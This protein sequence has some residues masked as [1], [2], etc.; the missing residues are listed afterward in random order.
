MNTFSLTKGRVQLY[1]SIS[2]V[3]SYSQAYF[4]SGTKL[5]VLEPGIPVTRPEVRV[6]PPS[7]AENC[8]QR[9]KR[10]KNPKVTLVCV[11]TGFYPDHITV[12]WLLNG[13]DHGLEFKTDDAALRDAD[14]KYYSITSRLRVSS[15]KWFDNRNSFTC[16]TK[17][18]NGSDDLEDQDTIRG[19]GGGGL[20]RDYLLKVS[21]T[22]KLSYSLFIAKSF[23]YGLFISIV[24]WKIRTSAAKNYE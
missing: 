9:K 19:V 1:D 4:G 23:L 12:S 21:Q 11:V 17:F 2:T 14:N 22:A 24:V 8:D 20:D 3:C 10:K 7:N 6:L 15:R 18:Y 13:D 16:I 5:T